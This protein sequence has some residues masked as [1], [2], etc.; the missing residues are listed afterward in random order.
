MSYS[1]DDIYTLHAWRDNRRRLILTQGEGYSGTL[2]GDYMV[3][4]PHFQLNDERG[5]IEIPSD[6]AVSMAIILPNG[7][8]DLVACY[9]VD[10]PNG[11][12]CCPIRTTMTAQAGTVK[13]EVR[14]T[15]ASNTVIKF[16]GI[17]FYVYDG[18]SNSAA[19]QSPE[20]SAL[21]EALSKV[22]A[23]TAGDAAT[24]TL[25]DVIQANGQHPST[26]GVIYNYLKG[27]Y[28]KYENVSNDEIDTA[29]SSNTIY[30][31]SVGGFRGLVFFAGYN[32]YVGNTTVRQYRL[33]RDGRFEY[34]TGTVITPAEQPNTY[35]W[36]KTYDDDWT[37][38]GTT[39]NIQ[40]S[41]VTNAK[42]ADSAVTAEKISSSAVET[43]KIANLAVTVDKLAAEAVTSA[44]IKD[45]AVI[46]DKVANSAIT[47]NKLATGSV[48][49][50]KIADS[51]VTAE[52]L[53]ESYRKISYA[54][55]VEAESY[56]DG[57]VYI[58]N[59]TDIMTLYYL[60]NSN[61]ARIGIIISVFPPGYSYGMQIRIHNNGSISTR[62]KTK[63]GGE[64]SYTWKEWTPVGTTANIQ[65]NA[66]TTNKIA[67]EN[68]TADK[69]ANGHITFAKLNSN[70]K[71]TTPIS[72]SSK[73]IT[74]GGVY[75][76][77]EKLT[78][79]VN[80]TSLH[81]IDVTLLPNNWSNKTQKII[82][83]QYTIT[84]NTAVIL[85]LDDTA[86]SQLDYYGCESI[87]AEVQTINN[88]PQIVIAIEGEIPIV[89]ITVG[90]LLTEAINLNS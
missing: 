59:A 23:V 29:N 87:S 34:R 12:F 78:N 13:G 79:K 65:D 39:D 16:Y 49:T 43:S 86:Y 71:D 76:S 40:D 48:T 50:T 14:L 72:G 77:L 68:I 24:I 90:L 41:A 10:K 53:A 64:D 27:N 66:V 85:N 54:H 38:I 51:A 57:G 15:T 42:I 2:S 32:N 26:S 73:L 4:A 37:P 69:I 7:T 84:E 63:E 47:E 1:Y 74:S 82:P 70:V 89:N 45:V 61:Y 3:K 11:I 19:E 35:T 25:D 5:A 6:T 60:L 62:V 33:R 52:K 56:G 30:I 31:H 67:N 21:V 83:S 44:K 55:E 81:T 9:S 88:I 58:D 28:V 22:E 80:E 8:E 20:F 17:D 46:T 18:V 75:A 36:D